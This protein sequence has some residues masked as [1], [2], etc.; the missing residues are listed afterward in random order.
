M[1]LIHSHQTFNAARFVLLALG[2]ALAGCANQEE[3][4]KK[5]IVQ[6][7][8]AVSAA[9]ADAQRY[10]PDQVKAVTDQLAALKAKYEQK[11]YKAVI[12]E[13]PAVL[14]KAQGLVAAKDAAVKQVAAKEAEAAAQ[15]AA[16]T[17]ALTT[18]WTTLS[19][20][21]PEAI[22]AVD[23]RVN[24]LAKSKKLP[25][26]LT[27]DA[28]TTAQANLADAKTAWQTATTAQSAGNMSDAVAAA[29]QAKEN[30]DAALA[31]LGMPTG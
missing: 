12:A 17:Q 9:G 25:A 30:A 15:A 29:R 24:V 16:A 3:P 13:A 4:A 10:V 14:A 27:K 19:A 26:N 7:E 18:D 11:D 22:A 21:V 5:A 6:I 20:A 1:S 2:L 28:L 23:S 31:S 8:M